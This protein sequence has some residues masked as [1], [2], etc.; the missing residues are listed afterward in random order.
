M[1]ARALDQYSITTQYSDDGTPVAPSALTTFNTSGQMHRMPRYK[2][3]SA[4]MEHQLPHQLRSVRVPCAAG[5]HKG[6]RTRLKT[7]RRTRVAIS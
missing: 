7:P 5:A 4:G 1:F 3:L 2:N 6:L